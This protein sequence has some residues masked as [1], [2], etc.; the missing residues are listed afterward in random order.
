MFICLFMYIYMYLHS[1]IWKNIYIY[2]YTDPLAGSEQFSCI[3]IHIFKH[4]Y[5][6]SL[7]NQYIDP[8]ACWRWEALSNAHF[9]KASI[10]IR[11]TAKTTRDRYGKL[12]RAITNVID[13]L[14]KSSSVK[15]LAKVLGR[16]NDTMTIS[17]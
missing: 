10:D 3:H 13:Q 8:L 12:L 5:L 15:E 17:R 4:I 14:T 2:M 1:H 6:I 9:S 16:C 11:K 7:F